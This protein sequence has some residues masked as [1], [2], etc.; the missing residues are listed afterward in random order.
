MCCKVSIDKLGPGHTEI[1]RLA[2]FKSPNLDKP[3]LMTRELDDR[4]W[5]TLRVEGSR[6]TINIYPAVTNYE[7]HFSRKEA[8]ALMF[9]V[10]NFLAEDAQGSLI[11]QASIG[12]CLYDRNGLSELVIARYPEMPLVFDNICPGFQE[13][14]NRHEELA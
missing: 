1:L 10:A 3:Y 5:L 4:T 8:G 7:D 14:F 12:K 6:T 11:Q 2:G 13:A 9:K